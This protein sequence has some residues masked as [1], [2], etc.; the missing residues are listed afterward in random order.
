MSSQFAGSK[1]SAARHPD[2]RLCVFLQDAAD[3][4]DM[5]AALRAFDP[6]AAKAL[7]ADMARAGAA[8]HAALAAE[9]ALRV[10]RARALAG[11]QDSE[12]VERC[13]AEAAAGVDEA[14][15]SARAQASSVA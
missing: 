3:A 4:G 15:G 8:L 12:H 10:A 2:Q 14:L 13:I 1:L 7:A 5:S 9:P 11:A 6:R